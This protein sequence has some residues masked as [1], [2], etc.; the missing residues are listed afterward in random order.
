MTIA[1]IGIGALSLSIVGQFALSGCDVKYFNLEKGAKSCKNREITFSGVIN[2]KVN[3]EQITEGFDSLP[4]CEVIAIALMPSFYDSLFSQI[5]KYIQPNQKIIFFPA[6]FGA[7]IFKNR[8]Q[9]EKPNILN[10]ITILEAVSYPWVCSLL[11][12]NLVFVHSIKNKLGLAVW[13]NCSARQEVAFFNS[14]F[15]IFYL[16]KNFLETSLNNINMVLHP[17]PVLLNLGSIERKCDFFRHYIDGISLTVGQML[18]EI[19][20]ERISIGNAFGISLTP[21]LEQLKSYYGDFNCTTIQ[22]YV[23][24]LDG[25]YPNVKGFGLKSRYIVEDVPCLLVPA[26]NLAAIGNI[27]TPMMDLCIEIAN[28][29]NHICYQQEGFNSVNLGLDNMSLKQISEVINN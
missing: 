24:R 19:D 2:S 6:S 23:N 28:H 9:T 12:K 13:P 18:E 29:A 17:L 1:V 5:I 15:S 14:Y 7:L 8:I 27:K 21:T 26:K 10:S 11:N 20:E 4:D 16:A 3:F 22:Q 25:P